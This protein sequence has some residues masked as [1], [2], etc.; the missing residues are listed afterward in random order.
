DLDLATYLLTEAKVAVIPGSVF[1]G[2]GHI[3][4]TYACSR[5]DIERGVERI[6]EAVSKLK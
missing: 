2:E 5:H 6:A 1:E 3:R 4:L